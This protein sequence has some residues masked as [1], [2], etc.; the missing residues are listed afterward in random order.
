MTDIKATQDIFAVVNN[1]T[2]YDRKALDE[3]L[4]KARQT[5]LYLDQKRSKQ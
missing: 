4:L 1:G 5:K 3:M 2:Y